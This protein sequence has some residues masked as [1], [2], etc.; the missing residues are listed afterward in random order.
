MSILDCLG[1]V[2]FYLV[3]KLRVI[4]LEFVET[5]FN[6]SFLPSLTG[7]LCVRLLV[8]P[9][10][11]KSQRNAAKMQNNMPQMQALQLKMTEARQTGNSMM[12]IF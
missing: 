11:V 10:V 7:T 9:L 1:G 8:F 2:R 4:C 3:I 6:L 5:N 12:G